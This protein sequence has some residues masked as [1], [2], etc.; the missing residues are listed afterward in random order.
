MHVV[1][2]YPAANERFSRVFGGEIFRHL[3][4][5]LLATVQK[6]VLTRGEIKMARYD[7]DIIAAYGDKSVF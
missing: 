6:Q 3:P 1:T 7:P 4:H 2:P 5:S